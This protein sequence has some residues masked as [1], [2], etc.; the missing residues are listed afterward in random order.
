MT[1]IFSDSQSVE[2]E[3]KSR[4]CFPDFIMMEN[5]AAALEAAVLK[6][7]CR[8]KKS[9]FDLPDS[10]QSVLILCGSGNNGG[11]GYALARRLRGKINCDIFA[12]KP[13]KTEEALVQRKMAEALGCQI[14][15]NLPSDEKL[16]SYTIIVDCISGTG[17]KGQ[18]R[19]P[20]A[21]LIEKVNSLDAYKIA[22]DIP[23]GLQL[24]A[25]LTVTM[26]C[27]KSLLFDDKAKDF[28]GKIEVADLGITAG[29][30]QDC[31]KADAF[32][33]EKGDIKL[34][35]RTNKAAHK[36]TYGHTALFAGEKSGAAILGA[37][38]A[39]NFGSGLVTLVKTEKS[40]LSQFKI[41]PELMISDE[42]PAGTT[43][44]LIGSG[45]G[46]LDFAGSKES[47]NP[48]INALDKVKAWF[49]RAK[50]PACL[51]DADLFSWKKLPAFLDELYSAR[52]DGK[53]IL[54]PHLKEL[55]NFYNFAFPDQESLSVEELTQAEKRIEAGRRLCERFPSVT[56]IMKSA[57][58]FIAARNEDKGEIKIYICSAGSQS[59]AKAGSGDV[60]AGMCAALLAQGYSCR[61]AAITSV[62][63][64][65]L[66][67]S[68]FAGGQDW[69]L[70][71]EKLIEKLSKS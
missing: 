60:L 3:A 44:L 68:S 25:D 37:S 65:A 48:A 29:K 19:Q 38:A 46:S 55:K 39:L 32:L 20:L 9:S 5:A 50:K 54:T 18:V 10:S 7:V 36:G 67:G 31:G 59:L 1:A 6:A 69:A 63:A 26:G 66:A 45:L 2:K 8:R 13:A 53:I 49:S 57:N 41:S 70:T 51:F 64:H 4:Y 34:P 61:D 43:G 17:F 71:A 62:Y 22:C 14:F 47:E 40:S 56:L 30:F 15:D 24:N 16:S 52:P 12:V 21:G 42:I 58:T 35:F 28:C 23:T 33:I 27:L 11:D